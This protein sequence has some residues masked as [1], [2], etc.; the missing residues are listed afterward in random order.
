MGDGPVPL[1]AGYRPPR[2]PAASAPRVSDTD[3]PDPAVVD[4]V[5]ERLR[6]RRSWRVR[7]ASSG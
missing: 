1:P 5:R 4:A 2:D 6:Y 7:G 3:R